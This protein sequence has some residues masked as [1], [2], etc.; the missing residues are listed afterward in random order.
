[1]FF[2]S[3]KAFDLELAPGST[4]LPRGI[5][6]AL[7]EAGVCLPLVG[8]VVTDEILVMPAVF[9]ND[10]GYSHVH[11]GI[12]T[13]IDVE[14]QATVLLNVSGACSLARINHDDLGIVAADTFQNPGVPHHGLGLEWIR[15]GDKQTIGLGKILVGRAEDIVADVDPAGHRVDEGR[16]IMLR[17]RWGIDRLQGQLGQRIGVFEILVTVV[18]HRPGTLAVFADDVFAY[19]RGDVQRKIPAHRGQLAVDPHHR[20]LQTILG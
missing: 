5:T 15:A 9:Y 7:A 14:V 16:V 8:H 11:H 2:R 12:R 13:G 19:F 1:V 10:P 4:P 18:F 17:N 3:L 6:G 20:F